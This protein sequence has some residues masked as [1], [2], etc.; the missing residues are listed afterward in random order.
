MASEA[1]SSVARVDRGD[2]VAAQ[3][4]RDGTA[5]LRFSRPLIELL[6]ELSTRLNT[7]VAELI[8]QSVTLLKVAADA[9]ARGESVCLLDDDL[10]IV[11]EIINFGT[12]K[13]VG[14]ASFPD[15]EPDQGER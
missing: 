12:S 6:D 4:R 3:L 9:Q 7:P 5:R 14:V 1:R 15:V 11:A 8:T 2:P 10:E 13:G